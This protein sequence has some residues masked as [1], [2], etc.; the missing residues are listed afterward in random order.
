M[1][2]N[3][4][5]IVISGVESVNKGA[6]LMLYAILAQIELRFPNAIVYLPISQFPHG[7]KSIQTSLQLRQSPN[8]F[9]RFLG[10]YH[11]T[12]ILN[13]I[14]L[15]SKYLNNLIPI[16]DAA[17]YLDASGLYF[18]DAMIQ[19][20]RVAQDLHILLK[21][22]KDQGTKI[23]YLPQAFGPFENKPSQIAVDAALKFSDLLIARDHTSMAYLSTFTTDGTNVRLY[24]DFT[25]VIK[26]EIPAK[27]DY[28][29]GYVCIIPN[30]QVIRK[31]VM[32]KQKYISLIRKIVET[33][34]CKKHKIF[35]IDHANDTALIHEIVQPFAFDIPTIAGLDALVVKGI[36]G[37]SYLCISSRF[38]GVASAFSSHVPC[39]TTSWNHKYQELLRLYDMEDSLLTDS[40]ADVMD[41]IT[42][43][44][45]EQSN[46][47]IRNRLKEINTTV[48]QSVYDMWQ[49]VWSI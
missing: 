22:Y 1:N 5:K 48:K 36:I 2:R 25:S 37:Q 10:K 47:R 12:G 9:V 11:L 3:A 39:L 35:F 41:K 16:R 34:H 49:Y 30:G 31:G 40:T 6:E 17:Y 23:I 13:R 26:G 45:D 28:L 43:Y 19:S 29:K 27:Y 15:R 38:H 18:S 42:C 44:L 33:I 4:I 8:K 21:G 7:I 14:G 24:P 20:L 46:S 32:S